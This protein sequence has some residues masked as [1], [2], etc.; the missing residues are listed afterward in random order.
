[1]NVAEIQGYHAPIYYEPN[2]RRLAEALRSEMELLFPAAIYGRWHNLPVGPHPSS[3]FQVAF[4]TELLATIFPWLIL[5]HG[6]FTIF[7]HPSTGDPLSD[8]SR[9]AVWIGR[10]R[11][12]MLESFSK[13]N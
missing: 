8:H 4:T 10:Q 7:L 2:A 13:H 9:H 5:T 6:S 1:M 3:M 11:D 12:L